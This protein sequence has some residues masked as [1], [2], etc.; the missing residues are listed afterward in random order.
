MKT[1]DMLL[2]GLAGLAAY[3]LLKPKTAEAA[4]VMPDLLG[5]LRGA[6][7]GSPSFS[8]PSMPSFNFTIPGG[9]ALPDWSQA[10]PDWSKLMP[11]WSKLIP[12][13]SKYLPGGNGNGGINIPGLSNPL[14]AI[15]DPWAG[16]LD[17][18][19]NV[20]KNLAEGV[21]STGV[22]AESV[23]MVPR[24]MA[25][26]FKNA[27]TG[28][29]SGGSWLSILAPGAALV[30]G[31]LKEMQQIATEKNPYMKDV[32]VAGPG[33]RATGNTEAAAIRAQAGNL[34]PTTP[35]HKAMAKEVGLGHTPEGPSLSESGWIQAA[36]AM[37]G[38]L[39]A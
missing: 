5:M 3:M 1:Q 15:A 25:G 10:I 24:V 28:N 17:A 30:S 12:D 11:D 26:A 18:F 33:T 39:Y 34:I 36:R 38:G 35:Q 7:G 20:N 6:G 14:K 22:I 27:M 4:P 13:W 16:V 31:A 19:G 21:R 8:M 29:V 37:P 23:S 2:L 9:G 32:A